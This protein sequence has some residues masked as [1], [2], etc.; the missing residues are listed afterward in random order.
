VLRERQNLLCFT[1]VSR[2]R[3]SKLSIQT[4]EH[5][6]HIEI[7]SEIEFYIFLKFFAIF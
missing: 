2:V 5:D 4:V 7:F 3:K 6:L 1:S